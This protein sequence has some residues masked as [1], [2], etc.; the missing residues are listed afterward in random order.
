M[1]FK[2]DPL[3]QKRSCNVVFRVDEVAVMSEANS[4]EFSAD[5]V[6]DNNSK[7]IRRA[8]SILDVG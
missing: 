7:Q 2:E 6:I 4:I 5:C 1:R 8:C 3:A